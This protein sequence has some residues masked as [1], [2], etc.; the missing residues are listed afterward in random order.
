MARSEVSGTAHVSEPPEA[1][2]GDGAYAADGVDVTQILEM[3]ARSPE[4][5]L[6]ALESFVAGLMELRDAVRPAP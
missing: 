2:I 3:L 6:A 1:P 5:R 4:E